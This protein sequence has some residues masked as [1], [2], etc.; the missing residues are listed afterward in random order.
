MLAATATEEAMELPLAGVRIVDCSAVIS[1]PLATTILADQGADVIKVEPPGAGDVLRAVGSSRGGMSGL[2]HVANRG[3]RS[4]ALNLAHESG[5]EILRE[6]AAGAD[7]FVQNFRP[8]VAARMGIGEAALR[9]RR[10]ELIYVSISGF[11]STGPYAGQRVYDNVIQTFS[12]MAA[13]QREGDE[14]RPIRQLACDKIT[15]LTAA[16]AISAALFARASGR[17]GRHLELSMLDASVAFLWPDAGA[18][19][20]LLGEG[21]AHQPTIGSRYSLLRLADGWASITVLT[22]AEFRGFCRASGRPEVAEDPRFA[23]VAARLGNLPALARLL[24]ADLA[25]AIGKLT[26]EEALARFSAEDV[27]CGVVRELDELHTDR[28]IVTNRTFVEREHPICGRLREPRPP[29][30]FGPEP[31]EPAS[32]APS[33]GQHTDEILREI[34]AGGRIAALRAEGVVA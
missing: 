29:A 1:G 10:P 18:D 34:G 30:R 31:L 7:V 9:E 15:A 14:P 11:G 8:G 24:T 5:R 28:Q 25:Q 4:L 19:H 2:F 17:G 16:Q 20:I 22:D 6:L 26:R 27:P 12:G 33:L 21:V 3:K 23:T 13:V 32:P